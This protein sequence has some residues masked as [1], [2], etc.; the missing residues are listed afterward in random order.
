MSV[1][2]CHAHNCTTRCA[3][4]M[5]MCKKHWFLVSKETRSQVWKHYRQ[6]QCELKPMPSKQWHDAADQAIKEVREMEG[7]RQARSHKQRPQKVSQGPCID[8][9]EPMEQ[10]VC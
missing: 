4:E 9:G 5:L 7:K 6:G 1:H 10:C 2:T 8:C 3:P